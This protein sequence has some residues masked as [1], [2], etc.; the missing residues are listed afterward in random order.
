[1]HDLMHTQVMARLA[2][3][4]MVIE[5]QKRMLPYAHIV[6]IIH[7]DDR[8]TTSEDIDN[9]VSANIPREPTGADN[10]KIREYLTRSITAV[11]I[12]MSHG[13]CGAE[14]PSEFLANSV[15]GEA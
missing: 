1:M 8:H 2:G 9:L 11:V 15:E 4:P 10:E 12:F 3:I 13:P 5:Y 7:P 6:V 14:N